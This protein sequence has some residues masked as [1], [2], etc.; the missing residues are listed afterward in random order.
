MRA[1]FFVDDRL[2]NDSNKHIEATITDL[3]ELKKINDD[4]A[5]LLKEKKWEGDARDKCA[6]AI[7]MMEAYRKDLESLCSEIKSEI[8]N[9]VDDADAFVDNSDKIESIMKV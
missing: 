3:S 6:A 7:E 2:R 1:D 8:E 9:L 4:I 5:K